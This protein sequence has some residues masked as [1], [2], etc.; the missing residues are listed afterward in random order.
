VTGLPL[1]F[2]EAWLVLAIALGVLFAGALA[3]TVVAVARRLWAEARR[4]PHPGTG[5]L[6]GRVGIVR[7][8][9]DPVGTVSVDGEIWNA[10]R[11]WDLEDA[12]P[13]SG[14][15]VVI[16]SVEGLTLAVRSAETWEIES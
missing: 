9:L 12:S 11:V 14:D 5:G 16:E 3:L 1:G 10:R 2:L 7:R 4:R 8:P 15:K 6:I 13:D